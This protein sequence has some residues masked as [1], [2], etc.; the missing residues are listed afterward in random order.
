VA[1]LEIMLAL[2]VLLFS[3]DIQ[4]PDVEKEPSG[5]GMSDD[6]HWGRRRVDEYQLVDQF[7]ANRDGP[8][9]QFRASSTREAGKVPV[10]NL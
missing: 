6:K 3:Y 4:L 2:S 5:E 9:I 1:Y 7:L 8:M 10:L